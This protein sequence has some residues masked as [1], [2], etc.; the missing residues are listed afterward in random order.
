ML[1]AIQKDYSHPS[2]ST[3]VGLTLLLSHG[4]C[5][6]GASTRGSKLTQSWEQWD[7]CRPKN[8]GQLFLY[9]LAKLGILV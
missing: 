3:G 6:S 4:A 2:A 8:Q 1:Q 5:C 9:P 7:V